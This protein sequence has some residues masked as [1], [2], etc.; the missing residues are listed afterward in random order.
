MIQR[1]QERTATVERWIISNLKTRGYERFDDLH[2][3]QID[4]NWRDPDSWI[5]GGLDAFQL[6]KESRNRRAPNFTVALAF[7]LIADMQ[8][9]GV[10]FHGLEELKA[11]LSP[12]PPSLYLFQ[13]GME[14]WTETGRRSQRARNEDENVEIKKLDPSPFRILGGADPCYYTEFGQADFD[15]YSRSVFV[16]G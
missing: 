9:R 15:E 11:Q 16:A 10:D 4:N 14:P 7:S 12:S 13:S 1:N 6:A 8:P 3:D 2:I 5:Q